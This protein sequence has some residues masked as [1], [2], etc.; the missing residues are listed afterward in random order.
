MA[1]FSVGSIT[2]ADADRLVA[3]SVNLAGGPVG[4]Y[5]GSGVTVATFTNAVAGVVTRRAAGRRRRGTRRWRRGT[6]GGDSGERPRAAPC[7]RHCG[8]GVLECQHDRRSAPKAVK[9]TKKAS[10]AK[11]QIVSLKSGRYVVV[12]VSGAGK[13]ARIKVT[14]IGAEQGPEG[15]SPHGADESRREGREPEARTEGAQCQGRDRVAT[16]PQST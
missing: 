11:V 15:R 5:I 1:G 6:S 12:R 7:G 9:A 10:V 16:D 13:T 4:A 2:V 14:L 8:D 3:G